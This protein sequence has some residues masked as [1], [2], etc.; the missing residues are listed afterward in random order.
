[1]KEYILNGQPVKVRPEDEEH[2]LKNN[3]TAE[4]AS[5]NQQDL[6]PSATAGSE[7][8]AQ[9]QEAGQSQNNQQ[10]DTESASEDTS[11][12]SQED[13]R[14]SLLS[15]ADTRNQTQG[16]V[17]QE[18]TEARLGPEKLPENT[19]TSL[20]NFITKELPNSWG[21]GM[22]DMEYFQAKRE[23]REQGADV[24]DE[25]LQQMINSMNKAQNE[26][27]SEDMQNFMVDYQNS[28]DE[29]LAEHPDEDPSTFLAFASAA[30]KNPRTASEL[31]VRSM[32]GQ[33]AVAKN[34]DTV[35]Q[36]AELAVV[37]AGS[38]IAA[39]GSAGPQMVFPEEIVTIPTGMYMAGI[40]TLTTQMEMANS[41]AEFLVEE[42]EEG[43]E[44]NIKN[45]RA[46][47]NDP[48]KMQRIKNRS[49]SR[50]MTIG[51]F[52]ALS[53]GV[54]GKITKAAG[55]LAKA[56]KIARPVAKTIAATTGVGTEA[57]LG[58]S[59]EVA[60]RLA[61][62][63]EMDPIEVGFEG[64]ASMGGAGFTV[65]P[66]LV[67]DVKNQPKYSFKDQHGNE[68]VVSRD[69]MQEFLNTAT[70]EEVAMADIT[71]ENDNE[72]ANKT[73]TKQQDVI[74]ESQIDDK[75]TD[76]AD[77]VKLVDLEK[78]RAKAEAD[79]KK[80]GISQVPGAKETLEG[81]DNQISE[82]IE[83]YSGIDRRTKA[84]RDIKSKA[85]KVREAR[86]DINLRDTIKF[87]EEQGKVIGKETIVADN[88]KDAQE[89]YNRAR[90]EYNAKNPDNQIAEADVSEADGFIVG[91]TIVINKDVAG[92][93]GQIN[94]G[95]HELLHGVV[96]KHMQGLSDGDRTKLITDF[97]NTLTNEQ[98]DYID[99]RIKARNVLGEGLDIDS[100][101]EWLNIMSDGIT[102]G[103]I[104]F[105]E[106]VFDKIKNFIQEIARK[107]GYKKEFENG[108]QVYN[109]MKDYQASIKK[110]KLSARAVD[111]AGEGATVTD[112]KFSKVYQ[113]VEAMKEDITSSDPETKRTGVFMA[114]DTLTNEVDRRLPK[115]EGI[116][117]EERED[118]VRDYVF[119]ER[120]GLMG[121]LNKYNPERNDS[122]MGYLNSFVPGT[123]LK[124][125]D[126]RLMEFYEK[127]PRF[128]NII[129]SMQQEGVTEKVEKQTATS[130][131]TVNEVEPKRKGI[132]LADRL[133][134][135]EQ[136]APLAEQYVKDNDL[137]G[138]TYKKT[139]S[140]ATKIVGD[141][142]GF[143]PLKITKGD[144]LENSNLNGPEKR[145]A[146][147]FI[148]KNS[149]MLMSMLPEGYSK[150]GTAT[151][152]QKV[153]L[154]NFYDKK[155]KR[156]KTKAGL[157]VQQKR[158]NIGRSDSRSIWY[159]R[160][161]AN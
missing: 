157:P 54:A 139:P 107:V 161:Q 19:N 110:N 160:W 98:F 103:E 43:Q 52:E 30:W 146:Q 75:V 115:L 111:L 92:R 38:L 20:W 50:G 29:D 2:F 67:G 96:A 142:M 100:T 70:D 74:L 88:N 78:Q 22:E 17:Q 126:A 118:I 64:F 137:T 33:Y 49:R 82:V 89:V 86:R 144:K 159:R 35:R 81:I 105:N 73:R 24:S 56:S 55:K 3:P 128:G 94:V 14:R 53:G 80:E 113:E 13:K 15:W 1:M 5:G 136:V 85:Q 66:A 32:A 143:N 77:R 12:E 129:Q 36:R 87:A 23:M 123:K 65:A 90:E 138:A 25:A 101:E 104:S 62:G 147:S 155:S 140:I 71:I 18:E 37:G 151:G 122:I 59:G 125:L 141:L 156:A 41:A 9:D 39:A 61:S 131:T 120:R 121:T 79:S 60:G 28:I 91:D 132:V 102:K 16:Q 31:L 133:K 42:L 6:A 150:E 135:R 112:T 116:T 127:D 158:T 72:L 84:V 93:T 68:E 83:K 63:Q 130:G 108:R 7:T 153:L 34:D 57:A 44:V 95:A 149:D 8:A 99:K 27:P 48:D 69:E 11:S 45:L 106:G 154:D 97:K 26:P 148:I 4:L 40:G 47:L 10:Q 76:K 21:K 51:F 46:V 134:V 58:S 109:F 117:L 119:N 145:L 152:V 114:A 124:L